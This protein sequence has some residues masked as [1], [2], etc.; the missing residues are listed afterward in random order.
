MIESG[1][2]FNRFDFLWLAVYFIIFV[3]LIKIINMQVIKYS[4]YREMSDKNRTQIINQTAPR[5]KIITRDGVT[6]A[7]NKPSFS[8]IYFPNPQN[9]QQTIRKVAHLIAK[10]SDSD[11]KKIYASILKSQGAMKPVKIADRLGASSIMNLSELK[12]FYQGLELISEANRFYPYDNYL[13]HVIGYVGKID[14]NDWKIYSSDLN[15]S[16]DTFVGKT[17]LEKLYEGKFKGKDGGLYME[18]DHR[19][20]LMRIMDSRQGVPGCDVHLTVD[21]KMQDAAEKALA[22]LPYKRG[23]AIALEPA[24]GRIL[25]YAVKPGFDPN[26]FVNYK[27][28]KKEF[29]VKFDEFNI[30][31]QGTY[32]PAS[33]FKMLS[34]IAILESGKVRPDETFY[35]P[36]FYDAG[37]RIFKCWEKKGHKEVD[38]LKG[39]AHSCDVYYYNAAY[40]MGP[41]AIE[42]AARKFRIGLKTGVDLPGEKSGNL[43]GPTVRASQK[44]YWFIGDTLNLAIGQ[45]ETLVTPMQMAVITAAIAGR[46]AIY[47]PYYV[48]K[49]VSRD[50]ELVTG[51]K[52]EKLSQVELKE[53]TWDLLYKALKSVVDEG[54]GRQAWIKDLEVYGKTGTA[55]NPH[56][57]DHAWFVAFARRVNEA[58]GVAVAVL[59]E[60]GEHGSSAAAP[61]ARSVIKAFYEDKIT[62]APEKEE[63][64][65]EAVIVE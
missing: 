53:E 45:G 65:G 11:G 41:L 9:S 33:V 30:G 25:A 5:G 8:L 23:C 13:S 19:G 56:G 38:L 46:G 52:P 55:Q 49:I 47:R 39:L 10:Y 58:P 26:I 28:D 40:K 24:T 42:T 34:T 3:F 61:V 27:E 59:I 44:S 21:F 1:D 63:E 51:G 15:Y 43:F 7:S 31:V 22:S 20:R 14:S 62:P 37:D 4:Y 60:H 32:P 29:D 12:N 57:K 48:E 2:D 36:G 54:T 6:M 16:M 17:G 64:A 35:C 50:G 18:V